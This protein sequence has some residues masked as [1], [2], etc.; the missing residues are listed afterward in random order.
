M[1]FGKKSIKNRYDFREMTGPSFYEMEANGKQALP[2]L[3]SS[4]LIQ[5]IHD[6]SSELTIEGLYARMMIIMLKQAKAERGVLLVRQEQEWNIVAEGQSNQNGIELLQIRLAD[7]K[8]L[9][10]L[11]LTIIHHVAQTHK[12]VLLGDLCKTEQVQEDEYLLTDCPDSLL[13]VPL[14]HQ[15]RIV[16]ILYLEHRSVEHAFTPHQVE[17]VLLLSTQAAMSL[18]HMQQHQAARKD[19]AVYKHQLHQVQRELKA[20]Q[21]Q[22]VESEKMSALGGLVA[23]VAHEINTPV[24]GLPH[25]GIAFGTKNQSIC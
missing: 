15:H 17:Q 6:M 18:E 7:A 16:G 20:A 3:N 2:S 5:A 21:Q 10:R 14:I 12:T 25:C 24:G 22:L 19:V 4:N 9:L 23:S 1:A 13:C 11:P 8:S